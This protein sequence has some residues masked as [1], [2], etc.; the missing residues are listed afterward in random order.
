MRKSIIGFA[1]RR[2]SILPLWNSKLEVAN[3][4]K[5]MAHNTALYAP[6]LKQMR[7]A[8]VTHCAVA[9]FGIPPEPWLE[10]CG[11][12]KQRGGDQPG[13]REPSAPRREGAHR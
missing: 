6:T 2:S 5:L 1:T 3:I 12:L 11:A 4:G 13:D 9:A 7:A 10:W 8:N